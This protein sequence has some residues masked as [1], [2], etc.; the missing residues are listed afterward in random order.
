M[1][2]KTAPARAIALA[3]AALALGACG[4]GDGGGTPARPALPTAV[5]TAG[6]GDTATLDD[7]LLVAVRTLPAAALSAEKL[8]SAGVA[9]TQSGTLPMARAASADVEPW[10]YVSAAAD[11][12]RVWRPR[13]VL[14]ALNQ[15]G[16][17]ARII[18]V[19]PVD[20]PDACLGAAGP[21]EACAQVITPGYR[22]VTEQGGETIEY[23]AARVTGAVRSV[24]P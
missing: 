24:T 5:T 21:G 9:A 3:V 15:A 13:V 10:E 14:D 8:E 20:W 18:S 11:G 12:W 6:A 1:R 23:H 2:T 17:G 16:S 19:E 7:E 4:G 22:I